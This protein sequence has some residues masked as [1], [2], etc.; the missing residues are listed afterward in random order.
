ME[1]KNV[2]KK[3]PHEPKALLYKPAGKDSNNQRS[4]G[5]WGSKSNTMANGKDFFIELRKQ[6]ASL[7]RPIGG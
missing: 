4:G 1:A 3:G 6:V 2:L 5:P 7:Q